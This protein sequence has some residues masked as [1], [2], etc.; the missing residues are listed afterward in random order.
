VKGRRGGI[1]AGVDTDLFR[2]K[3]FVENIT[4]TIYL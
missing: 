2:L 4:V 1:D 3:D